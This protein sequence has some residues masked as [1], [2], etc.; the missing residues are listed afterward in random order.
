MGR[1]QYAQYAVNDA[2][3]TSTG[4]G[5]QLK[6]S[7]KLQNTVGNRLKDSS[8]ELG[9]AWSNSSTLVSNAVTTDEAYI[10]S[11]SL[12]MTRATAGTDSGIYSPGFTIDNGETFTFSAYVKTDGASAYLT[13]GAS[14]TILAKSETLAADSGWTRLEVSY[15]NSTG[16]SITAIARLRTA[17]A[18]T[19][20]M[21]CV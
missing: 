14:G 19:V 12:A 13:I 20:Y 4:K 8:F 6:L 16:E 7:S 21:D 3:T 5:N 2:T 17:E 1:A 15:T 9:T 18:G 10:G 11:K